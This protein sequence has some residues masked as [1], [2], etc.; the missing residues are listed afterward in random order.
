MARERI[1]MNIPADVSMEKNF[2]RKFDYLRNSSYEAKAFAVNRYVNNYVKYT[3]DKSLYGSE[4]HWGSPFETIKNHGG[5]C[6]DYAVLK[7]KVLRYLGVPETRL[8]LTGVDPN[9]GNDDD[10]EVLLMNVAQDGKRQ[11]LVV[12]SNGINS[13]FVAGDRGWSY[14]EMQNKDGFWF[15]QQ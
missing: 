11:K 12:M 2:L 15:P 5:E 13:L 3:S 8:F 7:Y 9:G 1:F 14:F 4:I 10:H 6:K